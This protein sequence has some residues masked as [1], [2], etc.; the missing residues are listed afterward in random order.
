MALLRRELPP[1]LGVTGAANRGASLRYNWCG[2]RR[3][4]MAEPRFLLLYKVPERLNVRS[5]S[6]VY[7]LSKREPPLPLS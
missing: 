7:A 2:D 1:P 3:I 5:R 6:T 4:G